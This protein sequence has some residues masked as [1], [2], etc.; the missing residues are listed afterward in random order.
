MDVQMP[1]MD[2]LEATAEIRRR[3][4]TAAAGSLVH[5]PII[6]MTAHAMQGDKD[7]CLRAGM[8]AYVSKPIDARRLV[9]AI[10]SVVPVGP[11]ESYVPE[12]AQPTV[13]TRAAS[14][15]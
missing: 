3:E 8:D 5:V 15:G 12:D 9:S 13:A 10:E 1:D 2:G 6:A 11:A 4:R 14:I 7:R